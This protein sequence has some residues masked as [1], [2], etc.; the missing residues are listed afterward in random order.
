MWQR[1]WDQQ[2]VSRAILNQELKLGVETQ[3]TK[4]LRLRKGKVGVSPQGGKEG[5]QR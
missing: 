3:K 5:N 2:A 4:D 1:D